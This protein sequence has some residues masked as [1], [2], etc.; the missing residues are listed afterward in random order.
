MQ[1]IA[2]SR[3]M[4]LPDGEVFRIAQGPAETRGQPLRDHV[5]LFWMELP[6]GIATDM[7][8][9]QAGSRLRWPRSLI[10]H[11]RFAVRKDPKRSGVTRGEPEFIE[12]FSGASKTPNSASQADD[13][14]PNGKVRESHRIESCPTGLSTPPACVSSGRFA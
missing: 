4:F 6:R 3:R 14:R 8:R 7:R 9:Y 2:V 12:Q 11:Q 5:I 1:L 10:Q 13:T